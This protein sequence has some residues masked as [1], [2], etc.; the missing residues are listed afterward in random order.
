MNLKFLISW[1]RYTNLFYGIICS[2]ICI[3]ETSNDFFE[4]QF[5]FLHWFFFFL[6]WMDWRNYF[7]NF[8]LMGVIYFKSLIVIDITRWL[9]FNLRLRWFSMIL[10]IEN[11]FVRFLWF[12]WISNFLV[13]QLKNKIMPWERLLANLYIQNFKILKIY[14]QPREQKT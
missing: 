9:I 11:N 8:S 3:R 13:D 4:F 5:T 14:S 7:F 10:K 12:L 1:T 6:A 2:S